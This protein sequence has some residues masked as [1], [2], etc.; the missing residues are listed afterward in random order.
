MSHMNLL[1]HSLAYVKNV[2]SC[3]IWKKI[4]ILKQSALGNGFIMAML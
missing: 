2:I 1:L 3:K 4:S